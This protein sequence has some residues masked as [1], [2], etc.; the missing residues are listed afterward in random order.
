MQIAGGLRQPHKQGMAPG[1]PEG[2]LTKLVQGPVQGCVAGVCLQM[3]IQ[4]KAEGSECPE[5]AMIELQGEVI[6]TE[7][8]EADLDPGE[9]L[10]IGTLSQ[11]S[12]VR[13]SCV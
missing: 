3:I 4:V 2:R 6:K 5:W 10:P 12:T 7:G 8:S 13:L 11:G 9:P 1:L